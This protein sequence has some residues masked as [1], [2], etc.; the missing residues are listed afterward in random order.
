MDSETA[1]NAVAKNAIAF[2]HLNAKARSANTSGNAANKKVNSDEVFKMTRMVRIAP[3]DCR[4]GLVVQNDNDHAS[5]NKRAQNTSG[6]KAVANGD[7]A[8]GGEAKRVAGPVDDVMAIMD[9]GIAKNMAGCVEAWMAD[10]ALPQLVII[11]KSR[12]TKQY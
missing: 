5:K 9:Y 11:I 4:S 7:I 10:I 2:K 3:S 6:K 1:R 8:A 12:V